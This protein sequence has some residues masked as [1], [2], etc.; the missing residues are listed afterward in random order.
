MEKTWKIT[1]ADG[2]VL[3]ELGLNGN[4]FVSDTEVTEKTFRGKLATVRFEGKVNGQEY[5]QTC[6]NMELVQIARYSD[7]WYFVLREPS[8]AELAAT[9]MQANIEYIAMMAGIDLEG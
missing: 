4:N 5:I 2:T 8:E 6:R 9:R 3:E 7:G 1:L